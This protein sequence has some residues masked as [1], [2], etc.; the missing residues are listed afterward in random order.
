M[1]D[2]DFSIN[3]FLSSERRMSFVM[4]L[5]FLPWITVVQFT[6]NG[7]AAINFLVYAIMVLAAGYSIASVALSANARTQTIFLAP[8]VGILTLSALTAFWL[9]LG[10]PLIWAPALWCVLTAAGAA[11][12]WK[13]RAPL[14]ANTVA[15]GGDSLS[16]RC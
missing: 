14:A 8:A 6:A 15:Y 16:F 9:R 4:T 12:L 3:S 11:S 13:D 5:V 7:W 2:N 1:S 10:L